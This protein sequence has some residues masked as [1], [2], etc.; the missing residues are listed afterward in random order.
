MITTCFPTVNLPHVRLTGGPYDNDEL[1]KFIDTDLTVVWDV[2]K[3]DDSG[4]IVASTRA[5]GSKSTITFESG[6]NSGRDPSVELDY[7]RV[8]TGEP[9]SRGR[10]HV[11]EH[12]RRVDVSTA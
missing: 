6:N 8:R 3:V 11:P 10:R 2:M 7:K 5:Q 1:L 4:E 9:L 12:G